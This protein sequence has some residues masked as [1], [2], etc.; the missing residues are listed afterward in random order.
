M[1]MFAVS[2]RALRQRL[3]SSGKMVRLLWGKDNAVDHET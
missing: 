2:E 1:M 3:L